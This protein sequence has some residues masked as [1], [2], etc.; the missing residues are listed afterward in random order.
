MGNI[1]E[2]LANLSYQAVIITMVVLFAFR[3][4]L[5]KSTKPAPW[6]KSTAELAE[7]LAIALGLV[8]LIIRPF[9]VQ[10]FFI[11]SPS[12]EPTLLGHDRPGDVVHDHILVNKSV[13]L[14]KDPKPGDVVVF[15]APPEALT[16]SSHEPLSPV[17][18]KQTD[19]IKR[20]V[21]GPG[22]T[23]YIVGGYIKVDDGRILKHDSLAQ[24]I[25]RNY[26]MGSSASA[27]RLKNDGIYVNGK[28]LTD[29]QLADVLGRVD[30]PK[31]EVYPGY[32]VVNGKKLAED[33]Y[34]NEDPAHSYPDS[35]SSFYPEYSESI[36]RGQKLGKLSLVEVNGHEAIKL[37]PDQYFMMGDNRNNS[38]DSRFWGPMDRERAVGRAMFI[39][40]PLQRIQWVR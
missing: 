2:W 32:V 25:A 33:S 34:M 1:T 30:V 16:R 40:Y 6:V 37:G 15:H 11:P 35:T 8:F 5:L 29:A 23:L 39:F 18:P 27:V 21:A 26:V 3:Y 36:E 19:Y 12:M 22:D 13:Y 28:R 10:S 7:S 24:A 14:V 4:V 20:C 17:E 38:S 31:I 9:F